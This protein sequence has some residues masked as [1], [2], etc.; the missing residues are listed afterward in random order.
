VDS[1]EGVFVDAFFGED[2]V[3]IITEIHPFDSLLS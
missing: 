2:E 1:V 3:D